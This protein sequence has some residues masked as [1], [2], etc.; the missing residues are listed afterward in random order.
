MKAIWEHQ[1]GYFQSL[2]SCANSSPQAV[3]TASLCGRRSTLSTEGVLVKK[4]LLTKRPL[5]R[6]TLWVL[7]LIIL[8]SVIVQL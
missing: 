5:C 7:S 6:A 8:L 2:Q 3:L 4:K 1:S